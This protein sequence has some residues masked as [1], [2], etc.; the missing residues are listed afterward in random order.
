MLPITT[1]LA[2]VVAETVATDAQTIN[3]FDLL[4]NGLYWSGGI[5]RCSPPEFYQFV[6]I[7]V[8][9]YVSPSAPVVASPV[10]SVFTNCQ[11]SLPNVVRDDNY[12]YFADS[13]QGRIY[14]KAVNR[15]ATELPIEIVTPFSPFPP[16]ALGPIALWKE[17]LYWTEYRGGLFWLSSMD[18]DGGNRQFYGVGPGTAITK[19]VGF[20]YR[21]GTSFVDALF[22]LANGNLIR[23]TL[24]PGGAWQMASG[25]S[26]FAIRNESVV[27]PQQSFNFT[28]VYAAVGTRDPAVAQTSPGQLLTIDADTGATTAIYNSSDFN[29]M[30]QLSSVTVDS[31]YVFFTEAPAICSDPA[32]LCSFGPYRILRQSRPPDRN[33]NSNPWEIIAGL[34]GQPAGGDNLRSDDQW[35]LYCRQDKQISR[36]TRNI[37]GVRFAFDLYA[38]HIEVVQTSQDLLNDVRLVTKKPTFVRGYAYLATNNTGPTTFFPQA[39]LR[40]W[41]DGRE[42]LDDPPPYAINNTMIDSVSD[43]P[44]RRGNLNRS[45]LFQLPER[46]VENSG[47]L[48]VQMTVNPN[49]LL[50]ETGNLNNTAS[51]Q[52]MQL[53]KMGSPCLVMLPIDVTTGPVYWPQDDADNFGGIINRART[54][55]PVEDFQITLGKDVLRKPVFYILP[56][57]DVVYRSFTEGDLTDGI[58]SALDWL[59]IYNTFDKNPAGCGDTHFVGM[60]P[61]SLPHFNGVGT[62]PGS[63]LLVTMRSGGSPS[64]QLPQGGFSLAHELAHNFSEKHVYNPA[65]CG[66]DG[67]VPLEPF[68]N[69]PYFECTMGPIDSGDAT[70]YGYDPISGSVIIPT[71]SGPGDLMSYQSQRWMSK[72]TIDLLFGR[73]PG[74]SFANGLQLPQLL[75]GNA[76]AGSP[77][78]VLLIH[79]ALNPATGAAEFLPLYQLPSD[80]FDGDKILASMN[81]AAQQSSPPYLVRLVDAGGTTLLQTPLVLS[82]PT[83]GPL[84]GFAQF[85]WFHPSTHRVQLVTSNNI[86]LADRLASPHA[87]VLALGSPVVNAVAETLD[88]NWTA[89][90]ADGDP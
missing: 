86:V 79:G 1:A 55:L 35:W 62:R 58:G 72:Y 74:F 61:T 49:G 15:P 4:R 39:S 26:D 33:G 65:S 23:F 17:T 57:P 47:N 40:A 60:C 31:Q 80:A 75:T 69:Y 81:A 34:D 83:D 88:L 13:N 3:G 11:A 45:F 76:Q 77:L 36:I 10:L 63:S 43:L 44:T 78:P 8:C 30:N 64:W 37:A 38:D 41:L 70:T 5:G 7:G 89:S 18:T 67:Q 46:W 12:V 32:A 21:S 9:N 68:E 84:S 56:Y 53:I 54:L 52:S 87:P 6:D 20:S 22:I 73:I 19:M 48:V 85:V 90:D 16:G 51:S 25:I 28:T 59:S 14:K 2:D 42:L 66:L 24:I 27:G 71:P 29:T 82:P 50:H